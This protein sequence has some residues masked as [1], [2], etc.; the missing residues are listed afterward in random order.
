MKTESKDAFEKILQVKDPFYIERVDVD[1]DDLEVNIFLNF[2]RGAR[3][4]CSVCLEEG[5]PVFSTVYKTWRHL[6]VCQYK[7]YLHARCPKTKC[8]QC[9]VRLW[10]APW[11]RRYSGFTLMFESFV[12]GLI[13]EM[14]V[15][16]VANLL[17]EYDTRIWRILHR[18]VED[19][20][21][22]HDFKDV[23]RVGIDETS[24]RKGHKY[25]SVFVCMDTKK[26]LFCTEGKGADT[27]ERFAEVLETHGGDADNVTEVVSD[28]S[29]AFISGVAKHL[30]KASQTFNRFHI[31]KHLNEAID[32]IR[33]EEQKDNPILKKSRYVW[34]KNLENHTHNQAQIYEDLSRRNLKT[35]RAFR[36]RLAAQE[37]YKT[38]PDSEAARGGFKKLLG[39]IARSR[40]EPMK[41]FGR[42]VKDH[43]DGIL[44]F[45]DTRLTTGLV[46]GM[47]SR[48]QEIKRRAKGFRNNK[49][50]IAMI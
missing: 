33:R 36:I 3:F 49:N 6:N 2:H 34:L 40:L 48:I 20:Q 46:E 22:N 5:K 39:W 29:P 24:S 15:L 11:A 12:M 31:M 27:V 8:D 44:R 7:L 1:D 13:T 37:I 42:M 30:P 19:K 41:K 18:H 16:G 25:I 32:Q 38:A 47:N 23:R 35:A 4:A 17:G 50:F 14:S 10:Q 45:F 43:F 9:G 28:M 21:Q 26:V